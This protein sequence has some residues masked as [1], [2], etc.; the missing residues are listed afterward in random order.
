MPVLGCATTDRLLFGPSG[1][2]GRA[3]IDGWHHWAVEPLPS[4][5]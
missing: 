2:F 5:A 1:S 4:G 3:E